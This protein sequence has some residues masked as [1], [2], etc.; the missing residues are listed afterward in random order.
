MASHKRGADSLAGI[1]PL[2]YIGPIVTEPEPPVP[3]DPPRTLG[4]ILRSI[5]PGLIITANIVGTGELIMTTKLGAETGFLLLWFILFSCFIK[6][7]V[8]IELGRYSVSEGLGSLQSLNRLPGPRFRGVSWIVWLWMGMFLGTLFQISGMVVGIADLLDSLTAP[9]D[10]HLWAV[11]TT[12]S[13]AVLL[14]G[15]RYGPVEKG[16]MLMVAVFTLSTI[17]AVATLLGSG[18]I[19]AGDLG[20][21]LRFSLPGDFTTAFGAFAITGVGAAELIFYPVWLLEKG[22]GR[23]IGPRDDTPQWRDRARGWLRVMRIDAWASM[24]LYTLA[25]VAFY[26]LGAAVLHGHGNVTD[27]TLVDSLSRMYRQSFGTAGLWIFYAGAFMVL[28]STAF[29]ST[30]SYGR[31]LADVTGM[32]G[33]VP[34]PTAAVRRR[35][36]R[37]AVLGISAVLLGLYFLLGKAV[38]QVLVGALAQGVMLP[39]LG[40]A[41]LHFRHR[42]TL[43]DLRPGRAWTAFLW[44]SVAAMAAVGIYTAGKPLKLWP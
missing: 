32:L 24:V 11:L 13:L 30:A 33:I 3:Q 28:Y 44:I 6:V 20:R 29:V 39:F 27:A 14:A 5:G 37:G 41:A 18:R 23:K 22:Y 21:G 38:S 36:V 4:S 1:P 9:P 2:D 25:T 8:Q 7:F 16:S 42:G 43:P 35:L 15:G 31:L 19:T 12:A 34:S 40:L 26:L 17:A 10:R